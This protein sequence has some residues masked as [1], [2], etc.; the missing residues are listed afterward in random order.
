[1]R[2]WLLLSFLAV[3]YVPSFSQSIQY[4]DSL[5]QAMS[6][7]QD[8]SHQY[9]LSYDLMYAIETADQD[10]CKQYAENLLGDNEIQNAIAY[11][12][13]GDVY[14][15]AQD[16]DSSR[17]WY[18]LQK[19]TG[20][21]IDFPLAAAS[22]A[23]NHA[24]A[25]LDEGRTGEAIFI[26]KEFLPYA[27]RTDSVEA[28][29]FYYNLAHAYR[30]LGQQDSFSLYLEKTIAI[31][32]VQGNHTGALHNYLV[33]ASN[34]YEYELYEETVSLLQ[35]AI[36]KKNIK[37]LSE[38]YK[39]YYL[40]SDAYL[41]LGKYTDA[42]NYI[43]LAEPLVPETNRIYYSR[44]KNLK[45]RLH[46][47]LNEHAESEV[48]FQK[49]IN[50]SKVIGNKSLH[51]ANLLNYS[52]ALLDRGQ[53]SSGEFYLKEA[54]KLI[55]D[56][57]LPLYERRLYESYI[58][59]GELKD[60]QAMRADN[61]IKLFELQDNKIKAEIKNQIE[62]Q[63]L[64]VKI[65]EQQKEKEIV[66]MRNSFLEGQRRR[67]NITYLISLLLGATLLT[68]FWALYSNS[69]KKNIILENERTIELNEMEI[70]LNQQKMAS[71]RSQMNPHFLF[72]SLSAIN[73]YIMHEDPRSASKYLTK[74]SRLMRMILN[75]SRSR[76]I[77]LHEE[78]ETSKLYVEMEQLRTQSK[79]VFEVDIDKNLNLNKIAILPLL[80]QPYLENA[81]VHGLKSMK[82]SG[83]LLLSI[84][85]IEKSQVVITIEDNGI[86]RE[87][88]LQLK[89]YGLKRK[90][91]GMDITKDRIKLSKNIYGVEANL[92]IIDLYE[93]D[94]ASG[95][96]VEIIIPKIFKDEKP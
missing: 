86:G 4:I 47:K 19:N 64:K 63:E 56:V 26:Y 24:N 77:S 44:I 81:I 75:N 68:M 61:A 32:E 76:H 96:K 43:N 58:A 8:L 29:N 59:L 93:G 45:G 28:A 95:T 73:D 57:P 48:A 7:S 31:D 18:T 79:F 10:S 2:K 11:S 82:E 34:L 3:F 15:Y 74:F 87:K 54:N 22:G 25:L 92:K 39:L 67:R 13:L 37:S 17:Y 85:E 78:I 60:D 62:L 80:I 9:E 41:A 14:Y 1:M 52:E 91:Y 51:A 16:K 49:A 36:H 90:S 72:N 83:R 42:R 27:F 33:M 6:I 65:I 38:I 53:I 70:E 12:I 5:V 66:S 84:H 69:K 89:P 55:I 46:A 21:K 71:L 30:R 20:V 23:G 94:K 35:K 88:S 50:E 40:L